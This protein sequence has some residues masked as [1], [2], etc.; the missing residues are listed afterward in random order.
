MSDDLESEMFHGY[1]REEWMELNDRQRRLIEQDARAERKALLQAELDEC[2]E[3]Y[4]S[5]DQWQSE[6]YDTDD[7]A[8]LLSDDE[9]LEE[10]QDVLT[11]DL[12]TQL[13]LDMQ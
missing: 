8:G 3:A 7:E 1:S 11:S 10:L 13:D 5:S 12:D 6:L 2:T 4:F 9:W